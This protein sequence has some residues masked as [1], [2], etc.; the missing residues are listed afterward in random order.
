MVGFKE[1][2][3]K[4]GLT[5]MEAGKR[6]GVSDAAIAQW[7]SGYTMPTA[8]RL[9]EVARVYGCTVDELLRSENEEEL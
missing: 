3:K 7:E 8:K 1:A 2:R 9:P 6:I 5:M 4:A